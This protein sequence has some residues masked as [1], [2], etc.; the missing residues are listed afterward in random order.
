[1]VSNA[2]GVAFGIVI[3]MT[4][5]PSNCF[6]LTLLLNSVTRFDSKLIRH[7]LAI[8][9]LVGSAWSCGQSDKPYR[10]HRTRITVESCHEPLYYSCQQTNLTVRLGTVLKSLPDCHLAES[11]RTP[12]SHGQSESV[13]RA[14]LQPSSS[15]LQSQFVRLQV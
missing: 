11:V 12:S 8:A 13:L 3:A 10:D 1:M 9:L 6:L 2:A 5:C 7:F 15:T 14:G 4:A